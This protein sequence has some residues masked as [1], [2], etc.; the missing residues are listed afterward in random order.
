MDEGV[1]NWIIYPT[2]GAATGFAIERRIVQK[3]NISET[4][5]IE[6]ADSRTGVH[7]N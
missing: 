2:N 6:A 4:P 7:G 1:Y 5:T 3:H